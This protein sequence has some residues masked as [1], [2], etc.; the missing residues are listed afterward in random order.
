[1]DSTAGHDDERAL[2]AIERELTAADP[3]LAAALDTV[4]PVRRPARWMALIALGGLVLL[5]GFL[6]GS[7]VTAVLGAGG[8]VA[9][10]LRLLWSTLDQG[11]GPDQGGRTPMWPV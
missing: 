11:S 8:V 1:M 3:A 6:A 10:S 2:A 9:G 5:A 4:S 7:P